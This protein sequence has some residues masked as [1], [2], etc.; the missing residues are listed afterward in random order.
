LEPLGKGYL[1]L[2]LQLEILMGTLYERFADR[3]AAHQEFWLSLVAD[4]RE[5]AGY[6]Q[7]FS[8]LS[9]EQKMSFAEGKARIAALNSLLTYIQGVID[10]FDRQ[11]FMHQKALAI[12]LDL[13]K[14]VLER[15]VFKGFD[16][17][18]AEI[19]QVLG[20]LR[21]A[22]EVHLKKIQHFTATHRTTG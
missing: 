10:L 5:H 2:Y 16:S 14:S 11:P 13:E 7:Q 15:D 9:A 22:Q 6:I 21:E 17:D 1:E 18:S 3:Y 4:E 12:C 20:I 19:K 8:R